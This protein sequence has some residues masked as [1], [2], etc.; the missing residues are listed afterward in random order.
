MNSSIISILEILNQA[1]HLTSVGFSEGY[2]FDANKTEVYFEDLIQNASLETPIFSGVMIIETSAEDGVFT[3]VD[4]L[5]RLTSLGL[6]L[7]A[8][9]ESTKNTTEKNEEARKKIFSRYLVNEDNNTVKLQLA[10]HEQDIYKKI[11]FSEELRDDETASDLYQTYLR[12][13]NNIRNQEISATKLFKII[14]KIQFMII[15]MYNPQFPSRELYQSLNSNKEDFSQINLITSF[16]SNRCELGMPAW[17][18]TIA[19]YNQLNLTNYF[20]PFLRDFLTVQNDGIISPMNNLYNGFKTYFYKLSQYQPTQKTI[21]TILKCAQ[22]YLKIIRADFEDTEIQSLVNKINEN[23]GE[24]AYPYLME[25]LDDLTNGHIERQIFVD[26]LTMINNFLS[27]RDGS[28]Q[29]IVN[30]A[31]LSTEINKMIATKNYA[32][33]AD[34]NKVT[35]NQ[36]S[37]INEV[38]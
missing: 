21:E 6:L 24:E 25:V 14:S 9:C 28:E 2:H 36:L 3:I 29:S 5:Q 15:F 7:S 26:I 1:R 11:V 30:F 16:I 12:F 13:L 4:G 38:S 23:N 10:L 31:T 27:N 18:K 32:V 34:E 19:L 35:I 22:Y 37:Q 17:E 20:K 8:L 33:E